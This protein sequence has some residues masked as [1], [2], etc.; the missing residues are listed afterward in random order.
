MELSP[1]CSAIELRHERRVW[2]ILLL[3]TAALICG[4]VSSVTLTAMN[5]AS[6]VTKTLGRPLHQASTLP[7]TGGLPEESLTL[8]G[9]LVH[10]DSVYRLRVTALPGYV[11]TLRFATQELEAWAGAHVGQNVAVSG[12]WDKTEPSIFLV[13]SATLS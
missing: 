9:K 8:K 2:L 10:E 13:D 7:P 6:G 3:V 12:Y 11:V 1:I 5:G 4:I